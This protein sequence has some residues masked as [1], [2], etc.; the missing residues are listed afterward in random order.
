M[1]RNTIAVLLLLEILTAV[2]RNTAQ[3]ANPAPIAPPHGPKTMIPNAGDTAD[4]TPTAAKAG[5][6]VPVVVEAEVDHLPGID[7]EEEEG[8]VDLPADAGIQVTEEVM[9]AMI[10]TTEGPIAT[11]PEMEVLVVTDILVVAITTTDAVL[12]PLLTTG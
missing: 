11:V 7:V 5:A 6:P 12:P 4:I 2:S 10:T 3:E 1:T 8:T 9:K